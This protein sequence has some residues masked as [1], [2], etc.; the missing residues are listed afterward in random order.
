MLKL[1]Q[2]EPDLARQVEEGSLDLKE[3]MQQLKAKLPSKKVRPQRSP[4]LGK[5]D[6]AG[7]K[8]R[9]ACL[10]RLQQAGAER[11]GLFLGTGGRYCQPTCRF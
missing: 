3:A 6:R 4:H 8:G 11:A 10:V 2:A 9:N 7:R 5:V 1:R